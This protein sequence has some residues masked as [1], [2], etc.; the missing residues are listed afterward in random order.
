MAVAWSQACLESQGSGP[1]SS[2]ALFQAFSAESTPLLGSLQG[3]PGCKWDRELDPTF[4]E[5]KAQ[6][7]EMTCPVPQDSQ[8]APGF[9]WQP[10]L[11]PIMSVCLSQAWQG[12]AALPGPPLL[13]Q[14]D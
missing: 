2:S 3:S 5:T 1:S 9:Q 6:R 11:S 13:P 4:E 10:A 12:G 8:G 7:G 14:G